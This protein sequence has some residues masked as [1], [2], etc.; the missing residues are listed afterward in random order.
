MTCKCSLIDIISAAK[1]YWYVKKDM[2]TLK[3][4]K[5]YCIWF[6]SII[7]LLEI[8]RNIHNSND[9]YEII[10]NQIFTCRLSKQTQNIY[11]TE[12]EIDYKTIAITLI[13]LSIKA[14]PNISNMVYG[15]NI[16]LVGAIY[17]DIMLCSNAMPN[18]FSGCVWFDSYTM[19]SSTM[20]LIWQRN[21]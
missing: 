10:T 13:H 15:S 17:R 7:Q 20:I 2:Q 4:I 12:I 6:R 18:I 16:C 11:Y 5:H 3:R 8:Y 19:E 21:R 14:I 9:I 1:F